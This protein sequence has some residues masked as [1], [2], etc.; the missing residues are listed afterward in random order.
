MTLV[1]T[2]CEL[3]IPST[4]KD[5][6]TLWL[7]VEYSPSNEG[8]SILYG[9]FTTSDQALK[10][11]RPEHF[12]NAEYHYDGHNIDVFSKDVCVASV[13]ELRVDTIDQIFV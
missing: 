1:P 11:L 4:E 2:N 10:A 8:F 5:F 3:P 12:D 9:V 7:A 6:G 13:L